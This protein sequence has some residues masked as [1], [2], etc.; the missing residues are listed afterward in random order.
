MDRNVLLNKTP[1]KPA[2]SLN[3]KAGRYVFASMISCIVMYHGIDSGR[4]LYKMGNEVGTKI[5][6]FFSKKKEEK[7]TVKAATL[8]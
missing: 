6:K 1:E 2:L 5:G 4:K 7:E 3:E 8:K